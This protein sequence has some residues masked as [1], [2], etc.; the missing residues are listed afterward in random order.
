M[1]RSE[2]DREVEERKEGGEKRRRVGATASAYVILPSSVKEHNPLLLHS[3][4]SKQ[5]KPD[6]REGRSEEG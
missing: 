3:A 1:R 2:R 6:G 5:A 4:A